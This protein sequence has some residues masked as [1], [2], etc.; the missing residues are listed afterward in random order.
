[1]SFGSFGSM[2]NQ[3]DSVWTNNVVSSLLKAVM[4]LS[5][6]GFALSFLD[7]IASYAGKALL[8]D[9]IAQKLFI[10]VFVVWLPTVI[11]TSRMTRSTARKDLWKVALSGCPA[12]MRGVLWTACGFGMLN[13]LYFVVFAANK[14]DHQ[15]F[16][17]FAGGH[18]MV[19]YGVAFC[20][21]YSALHASSLFGTRHCSNGHEVMPDDSFCPKCGV[22]IDTVAQSV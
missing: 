16:I 12:W 6:T 7:L 19:F 11:V 5:F 15:P 20:V 9:G 4:V 3:S 2:Q 14:K 10:G 1:M 13:F 21:M 22:S 8:N 18:L 17:Q